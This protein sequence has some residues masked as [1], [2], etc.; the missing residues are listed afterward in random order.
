MLIGE[1][2]DGKE[3]LQRIEDHLP[4]IIFMDIKL[5]GESGLKLTE[6]IKDMYPKVIIIILTS[7]NLPE[8]RDAAHQ[9][10]A[11]HFLAK[12]SSTSNE[13]VELVES[14]LSDMNQ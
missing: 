7:Y 12:S 2:A 3:A 9:Y 8:Y 11:T 10:G 13:I 1:A 5:P 6:K 14:I 4:D